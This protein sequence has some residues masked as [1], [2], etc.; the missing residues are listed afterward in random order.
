MSFSSVFISNILS[1]DIFP[2]LSVIISVF[3]I[4]MA[5]E[6]SRAELRS[7]LLCCLMIFSSF[8]LI[9]RQLVVLELLSFLPFRLCF[10]FWYLGELFPSSIILA[11]DLVLVEIQ[12]NLC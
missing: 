9:R 2:F 3:L 6:R 5:L 11:Y 4:R 7:E 1:L 12:K 8:A 10:G